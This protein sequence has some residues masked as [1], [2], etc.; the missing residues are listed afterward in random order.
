M[1]KPSFV[2]ITINKFLIKSVSRRMERG[3]KKVNME[4][5]MFFRQLKIFG[6]L[7]KKEQI[8]D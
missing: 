5:I 1:R 7:K 4:E 3:T 6:K 8:R 2:S